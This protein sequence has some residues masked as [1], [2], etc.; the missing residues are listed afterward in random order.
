MEWKEW[1]PA[2]LGEVLQ[3][4]K[5]IT[6]RWQSGYKSSCLGQYLGTQWT[7]HRTPR[8]TA[9]TKTTGSLDQPFPNH[10][11]VHTNEMRRTLPTL[12]VYSHYHLNYGCW[13][14]VIT[15]KAHGC[16]VP[17]HD[18]THHTMLIIHQVLETVVPHG[19]RMACKVSL[20]VTSK[21]T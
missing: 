9:L 14:C 21:C 2:I 20:A 7:Y 1:I 16:V 10:G 12:S 6:C 18:S 4:S 11:W 13:L 15:N 17:W 8:N 19:D 5:P 3:C